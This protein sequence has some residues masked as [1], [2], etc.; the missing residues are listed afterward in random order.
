MAWLSQQSVADEQGLAGGVDNFRGELIEVVELLDSFD[1]RDESVDEAELATGHSDDGG[2]CCGVADTAVVGVCDVLSV[3]ECATAHRRDNPLI[4]SDEHGANRTQ[5]RS[6][7]DVDER[8][9]S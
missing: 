6:R 4:W 8:R 2:D 5:E 7:P 9:E 1:L 3:G